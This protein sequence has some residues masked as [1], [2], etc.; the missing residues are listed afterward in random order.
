MSSRII[1]IEQLLHALG[2]E[3]YRGNSIRCPGPGH[4]P[5]DRSL[6][7]WPADN[8]EGFTVYSFS[9]KDQKAEL[10]AYVRSK[11]GQPASVTA[12]RPSLK[13]KGKPIEYV[14][15]TATGEPYLRVQKYVGADGKKSYPQSHW[16]G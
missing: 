7:V 14:Y 8:R 12:L 2:G 9:P 11:L 3:I 16:D 10:I 1:T 15:Q 4:G 13:S 6:R 5:E